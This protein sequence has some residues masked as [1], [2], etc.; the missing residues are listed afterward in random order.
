[1]ES[2]RDRDSRERRIENRSTSA[3]QINSVGAK[4]HNQWTKLILDERATSKPAYF[5]APD[6]T[7]AVRS[8]DQLYGVN[9]RPRRCCRR[10]AD[11]LVLTECRSPRKRPA[12]EN[13]GTRR[14]N[15]FP[16]TSSGLKKCEKKKKGKK[17][18][19]DRDHFSRGVLER[20]ARGGPLEIRGSS[21]SAYPLRC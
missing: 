6:I 9:R 19:D 2:I 21:S 4:I 1:M 5:T 10:F 20:T 3:G 11:K 17:K 14:E 15:P 16:R 7:R 8:R 18:R 13:P 12:T